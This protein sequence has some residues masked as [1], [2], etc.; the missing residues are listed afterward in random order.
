MSE[1]HEFTGQP[2]RIS[3]TAARAVRLTFNPSSL[4]RVDR[5]KRLTA[6]LVTELEEVTSEA[7]VARL[8]APLGSDIGKYNDAIDSARR[9]TEHVVTASMWSV[10]ATT[11]TL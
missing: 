11:A 5:I 9:A 7:A 2:L 8:N 3:P 10:L 4:G 6:A 1:I